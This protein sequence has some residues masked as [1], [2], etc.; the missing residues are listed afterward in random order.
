MA[1]HTTDAPLPSPAAKTR[2]G[3]D[4]LEAEAIGLEVPVLIHGSQV[5]A[6]VMETTEHAEPFEEETSTMIV[7]PRGAVIKLLARVRTGHV[8]VLT[9]LR[10][11]QDALC[12]VIQVN[13]VNNNSV[14]YVKLEFV[15]ASPGFWGVHFPSDPLPSSRPQEKVS[16]APVAPP[17]SQPK[18]SPINAEPVRSASKISPTITHEPSIAPP[19][20]II[21]PEA[22]RLS[23]LPASNLS[24]PTPRANSELAEMTFPASLVSTSAAREI[25]KTP[26]APQDISR[27]SAPEPKETTAAPK[28]T[29][30]G[31]P[32]NWQKE[33]IEPLAGPSSAPPVEDATS[34]NDFAGKPA[35]SSAIAEKIAAPAARPKVERR[36]TSKSVG[37]SPKPDRPVFGALHTFGSIPAADAEIAPLPAL[38][39]EPI[40]R[41]KRGRSKAGYV[42]AAVCILAVVAAGAMYVRRNPTLLA[43][44]TSASRNS[45]A[46]APTTSVP[47]AM[48]PL[49]ASNPA[50]IASTA[51]LEPTASMPSGNHSGAESKS[52]APAVDSPKASTENS[53]E[54]ASVASH[55]KS[56]RPTADSKPPSERTA[57]ER[58]PTAS[59]ALI[60]A[61]AS[62]FNAKPKIT[63]RKARRVEAPLPDIA[64]AAPAGN[65]ATGS[66]AL[67]SL[68]PGADTSLAAPP[69]PAKSAT[70]I[71]QGGLIVQ[72]KL[73]SSVPPVYPALAKQA[74]VEGD[75]EIQAEIG[76][77]GNVT[78]MKVLSGP[79]LLRAAAMDA[80]RKWRYLPAKLDGKPVADQYVVTIRF[81]LHQ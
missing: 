45:A 64:A 21:E 51:P 26:V 75:V 78:S 58:K 16:P 76:I 39:S 19:T 27:I 8:L 56:A 23:S 35:A 2:Q 11:H 69:A 30:Y 73:I 4:N 52:T 32:R 7:F 13:S 57:E 48:N 9:N 44:L 14:H 18:P 15:Q 47:P 55:E 72:P 3:S 70:K 61:D 6:V 5:T 37:R 81:R 22:Q 77:S 40:A 24:A 54:R 12:K 20:A 38:P 31:L 25:S 53:P 34:R 33:A 79:S 46:S 74:G 63:P 62:D 1:I 68:L 60:D 65:A 59:S 43:R 67:G 80:L 17:I 71:R 49:Q 36:A 28:S 10:S 41:P 66:S 42:V 50:P 29:G